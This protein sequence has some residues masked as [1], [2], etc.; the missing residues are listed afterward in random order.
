MLKNRKDN[1]V[2]RVTK[3]ITNDLTPSRNPLSDS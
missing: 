1:P 3:V 2:T